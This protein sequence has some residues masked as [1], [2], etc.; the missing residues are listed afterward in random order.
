MLRLEIL[1]LTIIIIFS[2]CVE[3][4][5]VTQSTEPVKQEPANQSPANLSSIIL[6]PEEKN[7]PEIKITSFSSIYTHSNVETIYGYLFSWDDV[8]GSENQRLI[9]YLMNDWGIGWV[10]KSHIMKTDDNKNIR[11]FTSEHSL[12]FTLDNK[13][14]SVLTIIDS[15][16]YYVLKLKEENGKLCVYKLEECTFRTMALLYHYAILKGHF[17][18]IRLIKCPIVKYYCPI[19]AGVR[20]VQRIQTWI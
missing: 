13:T 11:I 9:N 14:N 15:E 20:N 8:P 1:I 19:L 2:G 7:I 16:P 6:P 4:N 18:Y 5:N 17:V 12:E 3:E 10:N